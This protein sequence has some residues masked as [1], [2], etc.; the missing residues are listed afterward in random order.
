MDFLLTVNVLRALL[1]PGHGLSLVLPLV[2]SWPPIWF[3]NSTA[4]EVS[5]AW[6]ETQ[7]P[8]MV[9]SFA[10]F[11]GVCERVFR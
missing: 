4:F 11:V 7:S 10:L 8:A 5:K 9:R 1:H 3:S 6:K 2:L